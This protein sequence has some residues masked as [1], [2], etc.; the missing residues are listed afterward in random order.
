MLAVWAHVAGLPGLWLDVSV[1]QSQ[2]VPP[3][4]GNL[5]DPGYRINS[6]FRRMLFSVLHRFG[7]KTGSTSDCVLQK[8]SLRL[9]S[10]GLAAPEVLPAA[11]GCGARF[12]ILR[13][14]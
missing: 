3:K 7:G 13:W 14:D 8:G 5:Q 9:L 2:R 11:G 6:K 1:L 10:A 12:P 4:K